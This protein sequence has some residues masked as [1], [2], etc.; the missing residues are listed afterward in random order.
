MAM[1]FIGPLQKDISAGHWYILHIMDY[2]SCYLITYSSLTADVSDVITALEDLLHWFPRPDAFYIDRGQHFKN[3]L[4]EGFFQEKSILLKFGPSR[5]SKA[6]SL[7]ERGNRILENVL[8]KTASSSQTWGEILAKSTQEVNVWII[9]HL[10]YSPTQIL[11]GIE[12]NSS[13]TRMSRGSQLSEANFTSWITSIENPSDHS[14]KVGEHLQQL[15]TLQK[16]IRASDK[17]RKSKMAEQYNREVTLCQL[18]VEMLILLHQKES[19][20]LEPHWRG[21]FMIAKIG[22]HISFSL[23]QLN[24]CWIKQTYHGDDLCQFVPRE[25]WLTLSTEPVYPILQSLQK[26]KNT[27]SRPTN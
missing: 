15:I 12:S 23:Q 26:P 25:G 8:R 21:P 24:G 10:H 19:E 4:V 16:D 18:K 17:Q 14:Q 13:V 27:M 2:F 22:D 9:S 20:K 1:N 5:A 7:I 6:F 11:F 3:Q